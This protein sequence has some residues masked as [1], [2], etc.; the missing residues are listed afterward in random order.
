MTTS[1][2][3]EAPPPTGPAPAR[4]LADLLPETGRGLFRAGR[5][6][7]YPHHWQ[8]PAATE[9]AAFAAM[10]ARAGTLGFAYLGVPWATVIDGLRRS[11]GTGFE[12]LAA[13]EPLRRAVPRGLRV[14]TVA[15]HIHSDRFA[16]LFRACGVTDLFWS[17]ARAGQDRLE[18]M[19]LHPFPLFP[20]QTPDG[21]D[22]ADPHRPRRWL[23]NF[24]GAYNPKVYLSDV[25]ARIFA[26]AGTAPDLRIVPRE[27]WHFERAVYEEQIAGRSADAAP[28]A[29]ETREREE[30]LEA[31]RD[32]AFTLCPSG[33]GPNSIRIGEALALASIPIILT[34]EL[35]L[36]GDRALWD[37]ACLIEEDS[38]E[39]YRRA[40]AR[41]RDMQPAELRARQ[42][43]TRK[44]FAAVGPVGYAG[45]ITDVI[46]RLG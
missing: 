39:G 15:Q 21:P 6:I 5:V 35:A 36:P 19:A 41:A 16:G 18:G 32:S 9:K 29:I 4:L 22:P 43:A 13:L 25:R 37:A 30:Y 23:A 20:A 28:L 8:V 34:R 24:I 31:I 33:S 7:G 42:A 26:D 11:S 45:L 27:S 10:Q 40:L 2:A 44:L 46:A 1:P 3:P 38:A 12:V 14:A 17:H